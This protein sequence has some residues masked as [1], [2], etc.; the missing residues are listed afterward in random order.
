MRGLIHLGKMSGGYFVTTFVNNAIPFLV[1]PILTRYL[2]PE[3]Y[4]NVALF[5][6]YLALVNALT[7]Y[8]ITTVIG[9]HFFDSDKKH[10]A[11]LIGNSLLIVLAFSLTAM[12]L[13][14]ITHLFWQKYFNLS[15]FWFILIPLTSFA[16]IVFS[17]G[18]TVLR[19]EKKKLLF[20]KYQIG[21]T[22]INIALSLLLI[23]VFLQGWQGRVG[24]IVVANIISA[25][26]MYCYLKSNG[27][28]LFA[29]SKKVIKSI[30]NIV[31]PLIPNSFQSVIISQVGIFFMQY[32]FSKELLGVYAV[33]FQ[34][35]FAIMLLNSALA[36]SWSPYLYEQLA[37]LQ[38]INKMYLTRMFLALIAVMFLGV[39][40][41]NIFSDIILRI[42]TNRQYFSAKKFIPWFTIG[43]FFQGLYIFLAPILIK[44]EKQKYISIISFLNMI[45]MIVMN[46]WFV[47]AFGFMG[48]AYAFTLIYFLM[49]L[50]FAWKAQQVF[51]L[52]WLKALKVWN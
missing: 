35:A 9:K 44:F 48:I 37:K 21:N 40:F 42:M 3:Q 47:R 24:G 8:S 10:I 15:L 1:L 2:A 18:M 49:F 23:V 6:F 22:A 12:L 50:A 32:Y 7:G 19:N 36:L 5:S 26:L 30:L 52:P 38:A 28:V 33:G 20:G 17:M 34:V 41:V 46:I 31:M 13:I 43:F 39:V 25:L 11:S 16:F 51:P 29:I 27:Y 45:T 4:A 14:F